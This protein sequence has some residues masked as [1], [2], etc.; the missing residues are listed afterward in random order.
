MENSEQHN[1]NENQPFIST[2]PL[3]PTGPAEKLFIAGAS[4]FEI[5]TFTPPVQRVTILG[6]N[7]P[8]PDTF[9][10]Y[11]SYVATLTVPDSTST[12][13]TLYLVPT[14][15]SQNWVASTLLDFGG[16]LPFIDVSVR[17]QL[18]AQRIGEI[19]LQGQVF[20]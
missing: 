8:E 14:E 19:V 12:L 1:N 15:D 6:I 16:T 10:P 3:F 5:T 17:P 9:G 4:A 18:G 11:D 20:S 7:L 2:N 13:A